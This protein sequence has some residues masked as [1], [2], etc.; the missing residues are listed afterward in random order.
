MLLTPVF[1]YKSVARIAGEAILGPAPA[2]GNV[3]CYLALSS[4][5]S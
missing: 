2:A 1:K 4:I 3:C 5:K